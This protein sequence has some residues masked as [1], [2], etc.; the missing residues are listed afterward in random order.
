MLK[1]SLFAVLLAL[2]LTGVARAQSEAIVAV[3]NGDPITGND[4]DNRV[5]LFALT[6][7]MPMTPDVL[8]RLRPQIAKQLTD[9]KL[10]FQEVERRHIVVSD[11]DIAD[12]IREIEQRNNLPAGGLRDRLGGQGVSYR[13]LVDQIRAQIG[14][15]RV[16]RQALGERARVAEADVDAQMKRIE[17]QKNQPEYRYSEIFLPIDQPSAAADAR[18]FAD[19]VI[20]RL[21]GGAAFPVVAAQFSQ[22]QNALQGGDEGWQHADQMD[23]AVADVIARMPVGAISNT[24]AVPGGLAIVSLRGKRLAGNDVAEIL[25]IRQAF[26]PF[27][28]VLDPQNPTAQQKQQLETAKRLSATLHDCQG[29]AAANKAAGEVRPTDPGEVR[30]AQLNPPAFRAMLAAL[31]IGQVSKPLISNEGIGLVAVCSRGSRNLAETSR[32]EEKEHLLSQRV[33]LTSRQ[34]QR[35]LRRQALIDN[36]RP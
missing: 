5:R 25:T 7:S 1:S 13:T 19:A 6:T 27:A 21:R 8:A 33:E 23:R 26:L 34:L 32:A 12:A 22:S 36:P 15:S 4:V 28:S 35:D 24:I 20:A 29:L 18:R 16:L 14:W 2:G 11:Q 17:S 30:L 10:R 3:V 9:E 31:P